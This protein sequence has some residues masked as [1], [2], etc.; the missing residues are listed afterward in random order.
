MTEPTE[1]DG[2][3]GGLRVDQAPDGGL[4]LVLSGR[5]DSATTSALWPE[6]MRVLERARPGRLVLDASGV[7]YCDGAGA[8]LLLGLR[9]R[10]DEMGGEFEIQGLP[11]E[12]RR[13]MRMLDPG[14]A[15]EAQIRRPLARGCLS[16]APHPESSMLTQLSGHW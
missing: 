8:G 2:A 13:L 7:D 4:R 1:N 12:F 6:T 3:L 10:Q 16:G 11:D 9:C 14:P 15:P 5:L